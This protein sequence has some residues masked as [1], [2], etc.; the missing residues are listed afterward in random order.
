MTTLFT[1]C[2]GAFALFLALLA[3]SPASAA[4]PASTLL[5]VKLPIAARGAGGRV[6]LS[7]AAN[8]TGPITVQADELSGDAA[9]GGHLLGKGHVTV[10]RGSTS[11]FAD[12]VDVDLK[13]QMVSASGAVRI[14][15]PLGTLYATSLTYNAKG[16]STGAGLVGR[17]AGFS[18]RA[19]RFQIIPQAGGKGPVVLAM[20]GAVTSCTFDHPEYLL[21]ARQIRLSPG[22]TLDLRG[23]GISLLGVRLIT[24]PHAALSLKPGA[25]PGSGTTLPGIIYSGTTGPGLR[26]SIKTKLGA[27]SV[28]YLNLTF[29]TRLGL[30]GGLD[31]TRVAGTP[32]ELRIIRREQ[33]PR[34]QFSRL[35]VDRLPELHLPVLALTG[36]GNHPV[37]IVT[38]VFAGYYHENPTRVSDRRLLG[39]IGALYGPTVSVTHPVLGIAVSE[40]LYSHSNYTMFGIQAGYQSQLTQALVGRAVVEMSSTRGRTPFAFDFVEAPHR[41]DVALENTNTNFGWSL[42]TV[43]DLDRKQLYDTEFSFSHLLKC[44][45][46]TIGYRFRDSTL[47]FSVGIPALENAERLLSA[48]RAA[49]QAPKLNYSWTDSDPMI[50]T[51]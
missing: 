46:P 28:G 43:Y 50:H 19:A 6:S 8:L 37:S 17:I 49:Q 16:E 42:D 41:V 38:D 51:H 47:S 34:R 14:E 20:N 15:N 35:T 9:G 10:T 45:R 25:K 27:G 23:A 11:I 22:S 36:R 24:V 4:Q 26:Y 44:L 7:T 1:R 5:P 21:S 40:A 30:S 13:T 3:N 39:R 32:I 31:L 29:S 33:D 18:I 12:E 2:N 48:P